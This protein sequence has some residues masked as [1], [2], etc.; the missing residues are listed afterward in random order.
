MPDFEITTTAVNGEEMDVWVSVSIDRWGNEPENGIEAGW[1]FD[2]IEAYV[3]DGKSKFTFTDE[4]TARI[5]DECEAQLENMFA[6]Y[7][8]DAN[9]NDHQSHVDA[10]DFDYNYRRRENS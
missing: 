7:L 9:E 6:D 3:M 1:D 8:E 5:F 10:G 2:G 4:V